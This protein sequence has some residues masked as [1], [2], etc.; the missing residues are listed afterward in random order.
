MTRASSKHVIA[1]KSWAVPYRGEAELPPY[2]EIPGAAMTIDQARRRYCEGFVE[3]A[4]GRETIPSAEGHT[5]V[6]SLYAI[7]RKVQRAKRYASWRAA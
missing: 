1:T 6:L 4:T 5:V 7:P 2:M 3:I